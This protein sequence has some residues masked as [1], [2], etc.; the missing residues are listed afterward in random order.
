MF[1]Y[2]DTDAFQHSE[3]QPD[4]SLICRMAVFLL[5][6]DG[7]V[8]SDESKNSLQ[9]DKKGPKICRY[10]TSG[11]ETIQNFYTV[12]VVYKDSEIWLLEKYD[13]IY[14][15]QLSYFCGGRDK[16]CCYIFRK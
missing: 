10:L 12:L 14:P 3:I 9:L 13:L 5:L 2:R 6:K 16:I 7:I 15:D 11:G 8:F 1:S 4:N